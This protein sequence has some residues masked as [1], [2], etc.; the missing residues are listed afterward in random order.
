M[1]PHAQPLWERRR[2]GVLLPLPALSA[3]GAP[4]SGD[5]L[6]AWLG[7]LR[8]SGFSVWQMLPIHPADSHGSPY[9]SCSVHAADT[10]LLAAEPPAPDDAATQAAYAEFRARHRSWLEDY[11]L[12]R[13]IRATLD[14]RPWWQWPADLR[15]RAP[16]A[17]A[18][19]R[20]AHGTRVEAE[21]AAQFAFFRRWQALRTAAAEH[22]VL[23]FG[24]LPL[25]P[26]HD[27]ADVWACRRLF[28][29]DEAGHPRVVAGVPPDAFASAGQRWG[30]P[31]YDWAALAADGFGWFIARLRTQLELFDAVRLDHFRGLESV[32]EIPSHCATAEQGAWQP[33]PGR[34]LLA[35]L[36]AAC[37]GLPL[38]AEDLGLITAPVTALRRE[39]SLPGMAVLQFAF[40]SDARN[41]YL[42]HNLE[43]HTVAYTGTHDNDTTLGWFTA[44]PPAAQE[45]VLDYLGRPG[46]PM[47]WPL[48]RAAL[49]S[50]CELAVVPMQ[51]LLGLDSAHRI[52][53]PGTTTG[54]WTWRLPAGAIANELAAR[55]RRLNEQYG[56]V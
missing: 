3:T 34:E 15:D 17:L 23:L 11:A 43:R 32:W 14:G 50:V 40:D 19:F 13:A 27:S 30:N 6:R 33:A 39:F 48:V 25:F 1:T 37:G 41:P 51:D 22:G 29:L 44:L 46:E 47:P 53:T 8:A 36:R 55:V 52:N 21:C 28:Q 10:S 31:V 16:G 4:V 45:R 9:Q 38:V 18:A 42:P 26:A 5:V 2:A 54:N 56:R 7:F 20:S 12:F 24:D 49:A 35:A